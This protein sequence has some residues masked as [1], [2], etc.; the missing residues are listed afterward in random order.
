MI[1]KI[2]CAELLEDLEWLNEQGDVYVRVLHDA[3]TKK[4]HNDRAV[5][6]F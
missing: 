5:K 6:N 1:Y 2:I 4:L 3:R